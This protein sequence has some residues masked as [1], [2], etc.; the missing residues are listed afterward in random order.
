MFTHKKLN[1][2]DLDIYSRRI[3]FFYNTKEKMGSIFGFILTILYIISTIILFLFYS[4]KIINRKEVK[5]HDSTMYA[6]GLPSIN[7]NPNSLYFAFGLEDPKSLSRYIDETIYFPIIYFINKEKENGN[8]ITKDKITLNAERCDVKKFGEKYQSLFT[9]DELN[10]SYCLQDYNLTLAGGFKYDKFSYIRIKIQPCINTTENNYHCKPQDVIDSHLSSAYFSLI[11]K[12]IG[13]NPL[14]FSMPTIPILQNLYSTIDKTISRDFLMYFGITEVQ[15]DIGLI[16]N[17]I[18][19]EFFLQFRKY[20]D[21]FY[22]IDEKDYLGGKE[23]LAIQIRLE[24]YI[25]VQKRTYTKFSEVFS[26]IGGYMQLIYTIFSLMTLMTK[27]IIVEKKLLNSLFN[28][29]VKKKKMILS[30]QYEKRLNYLIH[31]DKGEIN[32]FIPFVAKKT[33]EP[34]KRINRFNSSYKKINFM[35][36]NKNHSYKPMMKKAISGSVR[37]KTNEIKDRS[38]NHSDLGVNSVSKPENNININEE[39][40]ERSKIGILF[41]EEELNEIQIKKIF[42]KKLKKNSRNYSKN[43]SKEVKY[44]ENEEAKNI[45]FNVFD[46]FCRFSNFSKRDELE[47]FNSGVNFYR[48]QMS[49]I[50]FFNIIFLTE[51]MLN[52]QTSKGFN[53]LN[54]TIEIPIR[55]DK[56]KFK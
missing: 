4:I 32:S 17:N 38:K 25:Q 30:I 47:L 55:I 18:K 10:N 27:N 22:F 43:S 23:I 51:I 8:L 49:I 42:G 46:Y 12:D 37:L 20:Y 41:K 6:Q 40:N 9:K 14:N 53:Y 21:Q 54:Q 11:V 48:N 52:K 28:F 45:N 26:I 44:N 3:S 1:I 16:G 15:T 24:E 56:N 29:N 50:H 33:P 36:L 13:L 7:I 31:F 2:F 19:K 34:Y 5:T 39:N 35:F